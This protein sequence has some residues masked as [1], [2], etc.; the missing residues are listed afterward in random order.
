M[1]PP[2]SDTAMRSTPPRRL[3]GPPAPR[4][5]TRTT[6]TPPLANLMAL[7]MQL[8]AICFT[9]VSS[10]MTQTGRSDGRSMKVNSSTS[11]CSALDR[12]SATTPSMS[13]SGCAA[14]QRRRSRPASMSPRSSTSLM[15]ESKKEAEV[16]TASA[17][18]RWNMDR[19][20]VSMSSELA[21]RTDVS[22]VRSSC[23][24]LARRR[25]LACDTASARARSARR[26]TSTL[27]RCSISCSR[28]RL[29][30]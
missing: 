26:A 12:S 17:S 9:L 11:R 19:P 28:R 10:H 1:P 15:S 13:L 27:D 2:V 29:I 21:R 22:G 30:R 16:D 14:T 7:L 5:P 3:P 6:T 8:R 4:H 24:M 25:D 18:A 20:G 23:D